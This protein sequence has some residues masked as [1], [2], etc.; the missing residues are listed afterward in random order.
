MNELIFKRFCQ[1]EHIN[2]EDFGTYEEWEVYE[3]TMKN[4]IH[5]LLTMPIRDAFK[6]AQEEGW[7]W[8]RY[9]DLVRCVLDDMVI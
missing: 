9:R 8:K 2:A 1:Q 6:Y 5:D 4:L 7:M 3:L